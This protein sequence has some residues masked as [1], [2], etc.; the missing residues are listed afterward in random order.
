M[1]NVYY[2]VKEGSLFNYAD[3]NSILV[4][5]TTTEGIKT[6]LN[7]AAIEMIDWCQTYQMEANLQKFQAMVSGK[8]STKIELNENLTLTSEKFVKLLGV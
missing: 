6:K 3:D 7:S 5:S 2:H 4:S 1:N 8:V